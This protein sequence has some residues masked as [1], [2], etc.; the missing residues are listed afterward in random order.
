MKEAFLNFSIKKLKVKNN[1]SESDERICRYSLEIIYSLVTKISTI[2]LI[3]YL[4]N[5]FYESLLLLLFYT[6]LR[7]FSGGIHA[8]SNLYCWITSIVIYIIIPILIKYGNFENLPYYILLILFSTLLIVY[9]PSDTEKKPMIREEKRKRNKK[10][11]GIIT[12][13][14]LVISIMIDNAL[15]ENTIIYAIFLQ[16]ICVNPLTYKLFDMQYN[17]YLYYKSTKV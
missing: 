17:N 8:S 7:I 1:L 4:L 15:I 3:S 16:A 9:S 12:I 10:I 14:Y 11:T 13:L 2:L 6:I 5:I